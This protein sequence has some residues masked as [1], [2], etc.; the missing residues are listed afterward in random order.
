MKK[1]MSIALIVVLTA[2]VICLAIGLNNTQEQL[3]KAEARIRLL[4][5]DNIMKTADNIRLDVELAEAK[6][7]GK[8][9][10]PEWIGEGVLKP[11]EQ[12]NPLEVLK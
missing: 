10:V 4:E 5:F 9:W 1:I 8:K 3:M 11:I 12:K 7:T 6:T 2:A